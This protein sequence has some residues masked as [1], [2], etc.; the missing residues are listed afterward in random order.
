MLQLSTAQTNCKNAKKNNN[1][2]GITVI[3]FLA[4]EYTQMDLT[5]P[6]WQEPSQFSLQ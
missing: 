3:F 2:I 6:F 4:Y 5:H 1:N